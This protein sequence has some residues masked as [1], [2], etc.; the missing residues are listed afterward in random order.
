MQVIDRS[1]QSSTDITQDN[2]FLLARGGR[3]LPLGEPVGRV[4]EVNW[5]CEGAHL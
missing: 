3:V 2:L 4:A 5:A 1:I